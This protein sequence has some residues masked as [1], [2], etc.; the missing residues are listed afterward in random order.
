MTI[1]IMFFSSKVV[2]TVCVMIKCYNRPY[3]INVARY[4]RKGR[5]CG[6]VPSEDF[7]VCPMV[8]WLTHLILIF[9]VSS[10]PDF[11][12]VLV[13]CCPLATIIYIVA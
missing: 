9:Q 1:Y 10:W 2:K 3:I 6:T 11:R 5:H 8:C 4:L 13:S 7:S 12:L